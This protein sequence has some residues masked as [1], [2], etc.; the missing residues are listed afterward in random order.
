M[1]KYGACL[2]IISSCYSGRLLF[3]KIHSFFNVQHYKPTTL[4]NN[5]FVII[6][7]LFLLLQ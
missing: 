5:Y 1:L 4:S 6:E 3:L 7:R 2:T